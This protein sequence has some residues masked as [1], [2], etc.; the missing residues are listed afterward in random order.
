M[1]DT[2]FSPKGKLT[3]EDI[4]AWMDGG[5][6]TLVTKDA[7]SNN[8]EIEFVQKVFLDKRNGLHYPGSL[9]L[10]KNE[11]EIRSALESKILSAVKDSGWGS[12]IIEKE[13]GLLR[14]MISECI[15]FVTSDK[16]IE[17]ARKV[18]RIN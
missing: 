12:K 7:D 5:S 15:D 10:D 6:V 18:G 16:Y 14:Q 11:V 13:K 8:F 3:I 9:L 2:F 17:V 1:R 4:H